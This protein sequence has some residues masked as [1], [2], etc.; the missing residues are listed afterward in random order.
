MIVYAWICAQFRR[1]SFPHPTV[2]A[3]TIAFTLAMEPT[4]SGSKFGQVNI[5]ARGVPGLDL[6]HR[7]GRLPQGVLTGLAAAV[8][9]TPLLL[10]VY[11]LATKRVR[12]AMVTIGTF[13]SSQ[14]GGGGRLPKAS[15]VYWTGTF[16]QADRVGVDYISNQSINGG[17]LQRLLGDT[18]PRRSHGWYWP[19][20][21][22]WA[23][24]S[25]PTICTTPTRI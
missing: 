2:Y 14:R 25:W 19:G 9:L 18:G 10:A 13:R 21:S 3:V 11:F 22:S 16:L 15:W 4:E 1:R 12:P 5:P 20:W 24:W 8:K 7:T 6:S 23:R 17:M